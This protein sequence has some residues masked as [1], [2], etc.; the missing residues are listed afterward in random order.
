MVISGD[1]SM[2][3]Q[4]NHLKI[5]NTWKQKKKRKTSYRYYKRT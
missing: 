2:I 4:F 3:K 1:T 5:I